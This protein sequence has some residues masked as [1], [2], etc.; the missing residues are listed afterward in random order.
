MGNLEIS[1]AIKEVDKTLSVQVEDIKNTSTM[2]SLILSVCL[3]DTLSG[4]Y[5]GYQ[6]K[7]NSER[8]RFENF[9]KQYLPKYAAKLYKVRSYLLHSF[10][11][12]SNFMFVATSE[13]SEAF[14][15]I[16][17]FEGMPFFN[18]VEFKEAVIKSYENFL[19]DVGEVENR[20]LRSRF[21]SR[22]KSVGIIKDDSILVMR[23]KK[24]GKIVS[25][26]DPN[27]PFDPANPITFYADTIKTKK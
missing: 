18:L 7:G 15:N 3:I 1:N 25:K 11:N 9:T 23:E 5:G 27:R 14:P 22:Y 12:T 6:G 8:S 13:F 26:I 16:S 10:T 20:D 4:F 17:G 19:Q 21:M 2:S 24:D